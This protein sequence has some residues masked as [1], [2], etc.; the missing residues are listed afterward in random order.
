MKQNFN[1]NYIKQLAKQQSMKVTDFLALAPA[2]DPF[3]TGAPSQLEGAQWFANLWGKFG[4]GHGVHIRRI[5]YQIVSQDSPFIM[6]TGQPYLNTEG[7]WNYITLCSKWARYL[8]YVDADAFIDRRNPDAIINTNWYRW[9]NP[10]PRYDTSGRFDPYGFKIPELPQIDSL[11]SELPPTPK[12]EISGF[13]DM[14][15]PYHL[16]LWCEKTTMADVME[17]LG[18]LYHVNVVTGAGELSITAVRLFMQRVKEAKR[19]ARIF[20]ISDFDPAGLGMPISV[21]RKIEFYQ[22]NSDFDSLDIG[23]EPI[24][25]TKEQVAQY[26]LPRVPVKDSDL[27]KGNFE[28]AYGEGQVE[29][30]ALEALYP[31]VLR[32]ILEKS[33]L[34]YYDPLLADAAAAKKQALQDE[35]DRISQELIYNYLDK[36]DDLNA[37]YD[38]LLSEYQSLR[39]EYSEHINAFLPKLDYF[40]STL[41]TI[42]DTGDDLYDQIFT[43]LHD[44][45]IN[46][47]DD[48]F[49]LPEPNIEGDNDSLLYKSTRSFIE[50]LT[51]YKARRT[52]TGQEGLFNDE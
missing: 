11:P 18:R 3:Y 24:V 49:T 52:N 45:T 51:A 28:A 34:R 40:R 17:P 30:D 39:E 6:P 10:E 4:Y 19:P 15:Q 25:L 32:D 46:L 7:C 8:G 13:D 41:Q 29:L 22:R 21:S 12:I 50:Q 23:L 42:V 20:Y 35:A 48:R 36:I 38:S 26:A 44:K 47:E 5:H 37:S 33:I 27:R 2:N 16:E 43:D 14:E 1:Y 9:A 31:G